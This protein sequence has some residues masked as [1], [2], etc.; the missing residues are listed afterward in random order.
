MMRKIKKFIRKKNL[1]N[2]IYFY[3]NFCL[4][5]IFLRKLFQ[6]R[7][8]S[9]LALAFAYFLIKVNLSKVKTQLA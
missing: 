5:E 9:P 2:E 7:S 4:S 1:F 3:R 6:V 8:E